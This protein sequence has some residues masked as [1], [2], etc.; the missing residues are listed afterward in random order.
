MLTLILVLVVAAVALAAWAL[1][2]LDHISITVDGETFSLAELTGTH[3]GAFF[4]AVFVLVVLALVL[5]L[6]AGVFGLGLGAIGIAVGLVTT[7][8]TL[9]LIAAPFAFVVWLVWRLAQPQP[10]RVGAHP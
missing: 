8:G 2:P 9:A 7:L 4:V 1:L 3:A 5:A 10:E 6:L